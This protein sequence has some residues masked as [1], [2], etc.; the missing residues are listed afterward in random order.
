MATRAGGHFFVVYA[1]GLAV[2]LDHGG[3]EVEHFV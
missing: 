2:D 3:D 1:N